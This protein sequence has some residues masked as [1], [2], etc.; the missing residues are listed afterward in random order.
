MSSRIADAGLI[1]RTALEG[2]THN[3]LLYPSAIPGRAFEA[4]GK[5]CAALLSCFGKQPSFDVAVR[6]PSL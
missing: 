5:L 3:G 1:P 4:F 6:K 2:I